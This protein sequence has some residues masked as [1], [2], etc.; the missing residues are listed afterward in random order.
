MRILIYFSLLPQLDGFP[1]HAIHKLAYSL[2][3]ANTDLIQ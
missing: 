1:S 3:N 2:A